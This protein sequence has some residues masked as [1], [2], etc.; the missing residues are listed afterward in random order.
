MPVAETNPENRVSRR[1]VI[2]EQPTQTALPTSTLYPP[3]EHLDIILANIEDI[4]EG[5]GIIAR[6]SELARNVWEMLGIILR[7]RFGDPTV[8]GSVA[9]PDPALMARLHRIE[10]TLATVRSRLAAYWRSGT[11]Y[12]VAP[13]VTQDGARANL[14]TDALTVILDCGTRAVRVLRDA[15]LHARTNGAADAAN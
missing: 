2:R 14:D 12:A 11:N 4:A 6:A 13:A 1:R 10:R 7:R 15:C 8:V 9:E 3:E 5:D